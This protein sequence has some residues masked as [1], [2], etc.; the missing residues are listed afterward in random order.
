MEQSESTWIL[1]WDLLRLNSSSIPYMFIYFI[2]MGLSFLICG[3][4]M[5]VVKWYISI[6]LLCLFH[7][8]TYIRVVRMLPGTVLALHKYFLS[9]SFSL[10]DYLLWIQKN[11][12]S[13]YLPLLRVYCKFTIQALILPSYSSQK[14]TTWLKHLFFSFN[15]LP[16]VSWWGISCREFWKMTEMF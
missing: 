15:L 14:D 11:F 13:Q 16:R 10:N 4:G 1:E 7:K 8:E 9:L 3:M 2:Y 12:P 5:V 6:G